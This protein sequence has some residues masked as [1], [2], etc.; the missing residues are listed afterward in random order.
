MRHRCQQHLRAGEAVSK[1]E[2]C[3]HQQHHQRVGKSPH[4]A[5]VYQA[6]R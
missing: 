1:E 3:D 4:P 5:T 2:G 6:F